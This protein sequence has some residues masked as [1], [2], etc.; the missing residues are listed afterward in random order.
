MALLRASVTVGGY[1]MASRVLGF[2]R[3]ILIANALGA[4]PLADAFVVAFRIRNLFRRLVAEGALTS[5]FVPL[6][7]RELEENGAAT[8]VRFGNQ[9]LALMFSTL[10]VFTI[11]AEIAMPWFLFALAPGFIETSD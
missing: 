8:A 3:D 7:A 1:T 9:A 4:G 10:L 11:L 5:A 6:F 2:V